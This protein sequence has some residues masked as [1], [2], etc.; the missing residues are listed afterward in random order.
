MQS[1]IYAEIIGIQWFVQRM[2]AEAGTKIDCNHHPQQDIV[3]RYVKMAP[4]LVTVEMWTVI[5]CDAC[6]LAP[7]TTKLSFTSDQTLGSH[8]VAVTPGVTPQV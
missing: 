6:G 7:Q 8:L 1:S 4:H 2:L 5:H 3:P